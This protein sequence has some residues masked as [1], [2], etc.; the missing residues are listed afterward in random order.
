MCLRLSC[1]QFVDN[2]V[3]KSLCRCCPNLEGLY[4][5]QGRVLLIGHFL[6]WAT[7]AKSA[8]KVHLLFNQWERTGMLLFQPI[9]IR[10]KTTRNLAYEVFFVSRAWSLVFPA[11]ICRFR[12]LG[13]DLP[14]VQIFL[15]CICWC[16]L[17]A[18]ALNT[19]KRAST[20]RESLMTLPFT[21]I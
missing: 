10:T 20:C 7:G 14:F 2:E 4:S 12:F 13:L 16:S 5:L 6:S 17:L 18:K 21:N 19:R 11:L 15:I 8:R 1:C 9:I 3:I